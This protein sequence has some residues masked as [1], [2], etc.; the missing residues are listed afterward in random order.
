MNKKT[1]PLFLLAGLFVSCGVSAQEW[2]RSSMP[3]RR[4]FRP[5]P[6]RLSA[7]N[8]KKW[9]Q[10][11][12]TLKKKYPEKFAKIEALA[13]TNLSKAMQEMTDLARSANLEIPRNNRG[14][15]NGNFRR[16]GS[17]RPGMNGM[18]RPMMGQGAF[19]PSRN[20]RI[21]AEEQIKAKFPAEYAKIEKMRSEAETQLKALAS[22]ANITLPETAEAIQK[23]YRLIREKYKAEFE[24]IA[25]LRQTDRR[26]AM[27]R[28]MEIY[29]REGLSMPWM[30]GNFNRMGAT[31]PAM[32]E[33]NAT[34][35]PPRRGNPMQER[36]KLLRKTYPQEMQKLDALRRS[37]P[38]AY[39]QG[40]RTL[41]KKLDQE[42][43][44]SK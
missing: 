18:Q 26:A 7:E 22:K 8:A 38:A 5:A 2:N 30:G 19:N 15:R 29:K 23:K 41:S 40:L 11:Q 3:E 36:M 10:I 33:G 37:D 44:K 17:F 4:N 13:K 14:G 6:A 35:P 39:R 24:E 27:E 32:A 42:K 43:A 9:A 28:T 25:K 31:P 12:S 1:L 21:D 16:G 20:S 34:L